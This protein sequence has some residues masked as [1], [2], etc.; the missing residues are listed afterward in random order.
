MKLGSQLATFIHIYYSLP[1]SN[2]SKYI[3]IH[4]HIL[5]L[6]HDLIHPNI[7][8]YIY[9]LLR[10]RLDTTYFAENWKYCSKIIFKC[11]NN[12]VR[13]IFNENFTEKICLWVP[14]TVHGIHWK[15]MKHF[16]QKKE[17]GEMQMLDMATVSKRI[18][19]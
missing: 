12:A 8:I 10:M 17:E 13:P 1:W 4:P 19:N 14:W 7:Y 2:T 6:Y 16:S 3:Y 11:V 15:S 9:H 5:I 18:L